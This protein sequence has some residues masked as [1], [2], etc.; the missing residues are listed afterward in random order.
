MTFYLFKQLLFFFGYINFLT[1]SEDTNFKQSFSFQSS[2]FLKADFDSIK[3][4]NIH[5]HISQRQ[6]LFPLQFFAI[7]VVTSLT[8]DKIIISLFCGLTILDTVYCFLPLK[9]QELLTL[10]IMSFCLCHFY[11]RYFTLDIFNSPVVTLVILNNILKPFLW[12]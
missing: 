11:T 12:Q 4:Y 3:Y 8:L 6:L 10:L 9:E 5:N 7:Q 1:F 2:S